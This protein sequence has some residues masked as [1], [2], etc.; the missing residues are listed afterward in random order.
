MFSVLLKHSD[1][2][3]CQQ[4]IFILKG[5]LCALIM[6]VLSG[7]LYKY[8]AIFLLLAYVALVTYILI[9][10]YEK[11]NKINNQLHAVL[12]QLENLNNDK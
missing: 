3:S 8:L 2:K 4:T 6:G 9:N 1:K 7:Q 12:L 5:I 10:E 11:L